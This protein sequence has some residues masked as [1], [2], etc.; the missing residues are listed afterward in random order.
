M[1]LKGSRIVSIIIIFTVHFMSIE[2]TLMQQNL[3]RNFIWENIDPDEL[4]QNERLVKFYVDCVVVGA[5][6]PPDGFD[7][8]SRFNFFIIIIYYYYFCILII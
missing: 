6:C 7:L 1:V 8:R 2:L 5:K 4:I 3:Y